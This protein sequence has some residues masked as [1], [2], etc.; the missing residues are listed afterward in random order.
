MQE[1][2]YSQRLLLSILLCLFLV[3]CS[4]N[5]TSEKAEQFQELEKLTVYPTDSEPVYT[6]ELVPEQ[7]FGGSG[8]PYLK[9][10]AGCA[11]DDNDRVIIRGQN[12]DLKTELHVYNPDGTYRTQIGR[13][14]RGPGEYEFIS[15]NFQIDTGRIFLHDETT[16]RLSI[17]TTDDYTFE[18][19]TILQDWNVRDLEAVRDMELSGFHA[20]SDGNLLAIFKAQPTGS[21]RTA[22]SKFMLVDT[23]GNALNPEPLIEL[24]SGY[25]ITNENRGNSMFPMRM[26][27]SF[28]GHSLYV[29]SDDDAIYTAQTEDFLIKKYDAKGTY[30]FAFYYP[31][32]GPPFNIDSVRGDAGFSQRTIRNALEKADAEIPETA[33]VLRNMRIDDENRIWVTVAV[34]DREKSELWMLGESGELLAK[35]VPPDDEPICDIQ[36]GYLYTKFIDSQGDDPE[37]LESKVVKYS[38]NLTER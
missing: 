21:G 11:V 7:S 26:Q 15:P 35:I 12:N 22:N 5:S 29:V 4:N 24:P 32:M 3:Q 31:V 1:M 6:M 18:I 16:E 10:I 23:E 2:L 19:T 30:Q 8:K 34:E 13:I 36:N 9:V 17:F 33:P 25:Y 14:G 28:M 20:R 37:S 27:V 38:I